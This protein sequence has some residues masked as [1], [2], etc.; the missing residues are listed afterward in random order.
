MTS[1]LEV[2]A[3]FFVLHD[4]VDSRSNSR[5]IRIVIPGK[6]ATYDLVFG[7]SPFF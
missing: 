5:N 3:P 4:F 2:G 6:G 7:G 1:F